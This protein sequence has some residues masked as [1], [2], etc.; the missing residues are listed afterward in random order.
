MYWANADGTG[1]VTRLIDSPVSQTAW[2]LQP[3]GKFLAFYAGNANPNAG[4]DLMILADGG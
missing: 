2:S 4:N 1:D 3:S